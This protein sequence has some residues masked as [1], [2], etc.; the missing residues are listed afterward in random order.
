MSGVDRTPSSAV[1]AGTPPAPVTPDGPIEPTELDRRFGAGN[2][3]GDLGRRSVRGGL[4]TGVGQSVRF[5]LQTLGVAALGRLLVP[6]DF[7]LVAMA[8]SVTAF[9]M[10]FR[11]AGLNFATVQR[12]RLTH[13]QVS[14]LFWVNVVV[15]TG[16]MLLLCAAAPIVAAGFG[17]PELFAVTCA[18]ALAFPFGGLAV[19]HH[20]L[21]VRRMRFRTIVVIEVGSLAFGFAAGITA[22]WAGAGFWALVCMTLGQTIFSSAGA[23]IACR[24]RPGRFRRGSETGSLLRFG[25]NLSGFNLVNTIGRNADNILIGA[26]IGAAAAGFYSRAYGLLLLPIRQVN[27][28]VG[29]VCVPALSRLRHDPPEFRRYYAHVLRLIAYATMP[30]VV[31]LAI[32]ADDAVGLL[33]GPGWEQSAE[34]FRILAVFGFVQSIG[35]SV[36]WVMMSCGQT[37]RMFRWSLF[38][39]PTMLTGICVGIF[40]G[41]EGVA[42]GTVI[43]ALLLLPAQFM[44][45]LH[46]TPARPIDVVRAAGPPAVLSV[47]VGALAWVAHGASLGWFPDTGGDAVLVHLGRLMVTAAGAATAGLVWLTVVGSARQDFLRIVR[48]CFSSGASGPVPAV[49]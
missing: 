8:S 3:G 14:N 23:W 26:I 31:S 43:A 4:V 15:S 20:A 30:V 22:A 39:T 5:V 32:A 28:P 34:I 49:R 2:L 40:H 6:D 45:C 18:L 11:D 29:A 33:L 44:Y 17:R 48:T 13:Q 38:A 41:V 46:E 19:Q 35:S 47:F 16:L 42:I 21:L 1:S 37:G 10:V 24:W 12:D 9:A 27:A 36:G 25:W 7:G